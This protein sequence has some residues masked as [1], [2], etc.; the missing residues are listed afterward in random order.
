MLQLSPEKSEVDEII[1]SAK[2]R[3]GIGAVHAFRLGNT[4]SWEDFSKWERDGCLLERCG[5]SNFIARKVITEHLKMGQA[6]KFGWAQTLIFDGLCGW[7]H[8]QH[9]RFLMAV[10]PYQRKVL[11]KLWSGAAMTQHKRQQIYG[12]SSVCECGAEEQTLWHLFWQCPCYPPPP[13]ALDYRRH[14][15][16]AQSVAHLLPLHADKM[17][18]VLWRQSC[19]RAIDIL[20]RRPSNEGALA[21]D[22]DVKGHEVG[23]NSTGT[24][25][26]CRKCY[27]TRRI[28][29]K[30]W[31][32]TRECKAIDSDPRT[33]GETWE[34]NGHLIT[35]TM[36]RWKVTAERPSLC[37]SR[38]QKQVWATAGFKQIC[39][40][41]D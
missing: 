7:N 34:F 8:R 24:Y 27:I 14:L 38:C 30:K 10:T 23:V 25:A 3:L 4:V 1:E 35:L 20:S 5:S 11:L 33:I 31:I 18:I 2:G 22:L 17:E 21:R 15:P 37:C 40:A 9:N 26:Y 6:K 29:D 41:S 32:W 13:M 36:S 39:P 16:R 12:E 19:H 28:R